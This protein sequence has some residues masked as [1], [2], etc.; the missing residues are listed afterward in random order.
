MYHVRITSTASTTS[1]HRSVKSRKRLREEGRLERMS[2]DG[3]GVRPGR[4]GLA[5]AVAVWSGPPA[6]RH[7]QATLYYRDPP[8][9]KSQGRPPL[10]VVRPSR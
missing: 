4:W 3:S 5:G 2:G 7:Q 1:V 8:P 10:R 6:Q 9:A